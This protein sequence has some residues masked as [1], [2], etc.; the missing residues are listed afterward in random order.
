MQN[1]GF[2]CHHLPLMKPCIHNRLQPA[3]NST[4]LRSWQ[5]MDYFS[6]AYVIRQPGTRT[7]HCHMLGNPRR[8]R[9][10]QQSFMS[11]ELTS[12][13]SIKLQSSTN[14]TVSKVATY[15]W[16]VIFI[17]CDTTERVSQMN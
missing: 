11:P 3:S 12:T 4:T 6:A 14:T 1:A 16:I 9:E 17:T 15:S 2:L 8:L 10:K 13:L 5:S 7:P